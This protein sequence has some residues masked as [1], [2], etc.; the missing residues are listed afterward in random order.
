MASTPDPIPLIGPSDMQVVERVLDMRSGYV[1]DLN[2]REFD[3][4]IAHEV[5]IDATAPRYSTDGN[6]KAKRL[7]RI[8]HSLP[9]AQQAKLLR[10]FLEYRDSPARPETVGLLDDEWRVAY[11]RISASLDEQIAVADKK[12]SSSAWTG[13]RT[14]KEQ[15]IIVRELAPVAL[16]ELDELASL[17]ESKRFNDQITADAVQCLRELHRQLGELLT[18]VDD[19]KLTRDAVEAIERNKQKLV[20]YVH[21]GAK[22]MVVAPAMTLG[23]MHLLS[24]LSGVPV[25]STMVSSVFGTIVAADAL[26]SLGKTSTL[27]G[28]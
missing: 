7:R 23:I 28:Q 8:L 4:F 27:A 5:G 1:L 22:L 20:H 21:G 25:D 2:N 15:V 12:H 13:R 24:W 16:R 19:G 6:S 9:A 11:N 3:D 10:A 17:I 26:K 14:I 18:A